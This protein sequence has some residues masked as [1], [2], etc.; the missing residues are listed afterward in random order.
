MSGRA[1]NLV[2]NMSS[3]RILVLGPI[4]GQDPL[5]GSGMVDKRL[6]KGGNNLHARKD[7]DYGHWSVQ[8]ESGIVPEV[9]QQKWTSFPKLYAQVSQ[10]Y[11]KRNIEIKDVTDV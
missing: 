11:N 7:E 2:K 9:L 6:L 5:N 4:E 3:D 8:F 10:Y 1:G